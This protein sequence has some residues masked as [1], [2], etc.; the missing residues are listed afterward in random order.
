MRI[1][2]SFGIVKVANTFSLANPS[3]TIG[4]AANNGIA[5]TAMRSDATPAL[6]QAISPTWTGTH[7]FAK[8][9]GFN[10]LSV[11]TADTAAGAGAAYY[12][13]NG[14]SNAFRNLYSSTANVTAY[15]T[16]GPTG[17]AAYVYT[18]GAE[19]ISFGTNGIE[20]LRI[21]GTGSVS[22]NAA[23]FGLA[24]F[25]VAALPAGTAGQ[26]AF[27]T[28]ALAPAFGSTVVGGGA[29]TCPVFYNGTNWVVG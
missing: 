29:V 15:V 6:S 9:T 24:G 2:D 10:I 4:L 14:S 7:T 27:V 19:P 13:V 1:Y 23:A 5:L 21:S 22:M 12:L 17:A 20:R 25:T 18:T 8:A 28:N 26:T 3:A 11:S 16:N